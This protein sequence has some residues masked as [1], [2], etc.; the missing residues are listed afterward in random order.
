MKNDYLEQK[1]LKIT[2]YFS[3]IF[4]VHQIYQNQIN[5]NISTYGLYELSN[6]IYQNVSKNSL[7]PYYNEISIELNLSCENLAS[8]ISNYGMSPLMIYYIHSMEDI[9]QN[10]IKKINEA[11]NSGFIFDEFIYGTE[12]YKNILPNNTE[13]LERYNELNPFNLIN[14][15]QLKHLNI[16]NERVFKPAHKTLTDSISLDIYNILQKI[17]RNQ[18]GIILCFFLTILI[19]NIFLY[20]PFLYKKNDEIKQVKQ[21]LI[22]IPQ[23]VLY[24]ILIDE[25][26]KKDKKDT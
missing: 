10:I 6:K 7:C 24:E 4:Q 25:E 21:M 26:K 3:S 2:E 8:N 9:L 1:I 12:E 11:Q 19:F 18:N 22:L 16:L 14:L 23:N 17:E 13:D 15:E 5:S 20:F